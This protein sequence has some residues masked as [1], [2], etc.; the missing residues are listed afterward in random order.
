MKILSPYTSGTIS[1]P[2]F[3]GSSQQRGCGIL[4]RSTPKI[5]GFS[6]FSFSFL[7]L[8]G[9]IKICTHCGEPLRRGFRL[10]G[11]GYHAFS[12]PSIIPIGIGVCHTAH[13][14]S[15]FV[16]LFFFGFRRDA[17]A[18]NTTRTKKVLNLVDDYYEARFLSNW[19]QLYPIPFS[20]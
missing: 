10:G 20:K 18:T 6:S 16:F 2:R 1:L 5:G 11:S 7:R 15:V 19:I 9:G 12:A 8:L 13:N 4:L 3:D 14:F 17:D